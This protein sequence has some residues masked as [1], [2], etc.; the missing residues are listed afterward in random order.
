MASNYFSSQHKLGLNSAFTNLASQVLYVVIVPLFF[1]G[2]TILYRPERL[3]SFLTIHNYPYGFN[4]TIITLIILGVM[5]VSRGIY[6]LIVH[7]SA[8]HFRFWVLW[9]L[10]ELITMALFVAMYITLM[11]HDIADYPFYVVVGKTLVMLGAV[12]L[13]SYLAIG[14]GLV[15]AEQKELTPVEDDSLMRFLDSQ[16]QVKFMIASSA[17]LYIEAQ[18]NYVLIKYLDGSVI[19]EYS[20]RSSMAGLEP[21]MVKHGFVRCQRSY[22]INPTHVKALRKDKE[23]AISAELDAPQQ[24]AIPVSPRYYEALTAKL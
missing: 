5:I 19:K 3:V 12:N 20:L 6:L 1:L 13:Y 2:F 14:L 22:Y 21:L 7:S 17:V 23:G 15:Y 11:Y 8:T 9:Q 24:K 16:K 18:E 4:V 10:V